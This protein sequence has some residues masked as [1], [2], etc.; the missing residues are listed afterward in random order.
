MMANA[1]EVLDLS[2]HE[3]AEAAAR[4]LQAFLQERIRAEIAQDA[5]DGFTYRGPA[6]ENVMLREPDHPNDESWARGAWH[7]VWEEGPFEWAIWLTGGASL[8]AGEG[9]GMGTPQV[10][11]F[12]SRRWIAEP[13]WSFSLCFRD[14]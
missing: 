1:A 2:Q 14:D 6:A 13:G 5:D 4:A 11:G 10:V 3:T 8:Y 7:L 12:H 9:Y